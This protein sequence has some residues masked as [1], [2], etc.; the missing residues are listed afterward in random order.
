MYAR[1]RMA[2]LG[3]FGLAAVVWASVALLLTTRFPEGLPTQATGAVLL[4]LA[5]ALTTVPLFW[6]AAFGRHR[7]IAY[8]G[9]WLK[10]ARR[11]TWIGI[12]VAAFVLLR[13]QGA[14]SPP[15]G[16]FM[17]AMVVFVEISLSVEP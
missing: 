4:G 14:F 9:D 13:S 7:R 10:A 12:L 5:F 2:S 16:L 1:D 17:A 15:I 11:G 6:L 3:L 8:R